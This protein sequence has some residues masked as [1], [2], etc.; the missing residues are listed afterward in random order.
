MQRAQQPQQGEPEQKRGTSSQPPELDQAHLS[1]VKKLEKD[2]N[3]QHDEPVQQH[4]SSRSRQR[5]QHQ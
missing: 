1:N 4:R 3:R 2:V 5:S